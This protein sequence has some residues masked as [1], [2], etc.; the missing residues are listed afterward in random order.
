MSDHK[1]NENGCLGKSCSLL[2][3][4]EIIGVHKSSVT[5]AIKTGRLKASLVDEAGKKKVLIARGVL[6]WYAST[7]QNMSSNKEMASFQYVGNIPTANASDQY[8]K[9]LQARSLERKDFEEDKKSVPIDQAFNDFQQALK[10]VNETMQNV[11][12]RID[13][14]LAAETSPSKVARIVNDENRKALMSLCASKIVFLKEKHEQSS[15]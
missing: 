6:E 1:V 9:F 3:F 5:K 11:G 13:K 4:S 8:I 15:R 10:E 12:F 7:K 14:E 2:E